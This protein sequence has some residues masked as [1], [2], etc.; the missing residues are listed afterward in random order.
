M[1]I[2]FRIKSSR[3]QQRLTLKDLAEKTGFSASFFSQLERGR[4]SPS[5][6]SLEKIACALNTD[7]SY[8]LEGKKDHE[9]V[10]IRKGSSKKLIVKEKQI[11]VETLAS[12]IFGIKMQPQVF[13][14]SIS[15]ELSSDSICIAKETFGM[16][17]KGRLEFCWNKEKLILAKGDSIY[18]ANTGKLYGITNIGRGVANL[19]WI[20]FSSQAN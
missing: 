12:G 11:S 13:A 19:L 8:F 3:I 16:V 6:R 18:L 7:V 10:L 15:S 14:L 1:K 20:S 4:L 5:M 2:G 9:I 17:L